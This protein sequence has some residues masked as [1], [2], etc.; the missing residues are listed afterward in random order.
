MAWNKV[1]NPILKILT[2]FFC[3][4]AS[5][6]HEISYFRARKQCQC[7]SFHLNWNILDPL[8]E[9]QA[10]GFPLACISTS[11]FSKAAC[12]K[13]V[14]VTTALPYSIRKVTLR[15]IPETQ[16]D[17]GSQKRGFYIYAHLTG[18]SANVDLIISWRISKK[19]NYVFNAYLKAILWAFHL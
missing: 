10:H 16:R 15:C 18:A 14:E 4:V 9:S 11:L 8:K 12:S 5:C 3:E 6:L 7:C 13:C 2:L 1:I 17:E 19:A